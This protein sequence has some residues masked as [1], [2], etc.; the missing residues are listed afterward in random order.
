[1]ASLVR[2]WYVLVAGIVIAAAAVAGVSTSVPA[3]YTQISSAVLIP[4]KGVFP[5]GGNP[6]LYLG[7]LTQQRDLLVRTML[8]D[9][10]MSR[11]VNGDPQAELV[12]EIDGTTAGP[13]V[14][15]QATSS[16]P[17]GAT[18]LLQRANDA[19]VI[20]LGRLQAEVD[21]PPSAQTTLLP[22]AQDAEP[23]RSL[24]AQLQLSVV[25]GGGILLI[26]L[27]AAVWLDGRSPRRVAPSDEESGDSRIADPVTRS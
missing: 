10:V 23:D 1:M 13:V 4:A 6:F 27:I 26:T 5:E 25:V 12:V 21:T 8:S 9:D 20:E 3:S 16:S 22:L 19:L 2:R 15:L 7:G 24:K 14:V 11:V 18:S 17:D